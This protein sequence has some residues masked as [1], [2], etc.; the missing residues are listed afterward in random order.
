MYLDLDLDATD[1]NESQCMLGLRVVLQL[2]SYL[3]QIQWRIPGG[4]TY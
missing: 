1:K 3:K 2:T 4:Q